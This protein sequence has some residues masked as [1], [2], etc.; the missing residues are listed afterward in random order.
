MN[1]LHIDTERF[2]TLSIDLD[3]YLDHFDPVIGERRALHVAIHD[4]PLSAHWTPISLVVKEYEGC[5][6]PD[7]SSWHAGNLVLNQ[8]AVEAL[9]PHLDACGEILPLKSDLGDYYFFNCLKSVPADQ[10]EGAGDFAIVKS[11]PTAG[12]DLLCS[13]AFKASVENAGLT[14]IYFTSDITAFN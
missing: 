9:R 2:Y 7:I 3:E 10:L 14:G 5:A 1:K 8:K 4:L 11:S 13:D 6:L 12:L